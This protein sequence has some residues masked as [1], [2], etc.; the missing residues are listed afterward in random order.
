LIAETF[1]YNLIFPTMGLVIGDVAVQSSGSGATI[2]NRS[3]TT[4]V[5]TLSSVS[6]AQRYFPYIASE[7]ANKYEVGG[8]ENGQL[9]TTTATS[10]TFDSYGNPTQVSNTVTDTDSG[11]PYNGQSW[12]T[13]TTNTP[14]V[15]TTHWCLNLLTAK[16][17]A[18]S[19]SNGVSV[20][21][22]PY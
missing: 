15:D 6:G 14:S 5:T 16:Q 2:V 22:W 13:V 11:S 12:T 1:T 20:R 18:Y 3:G 17:T 8:T 10:Y 9:I 19:A 21:P 7:A 4:A